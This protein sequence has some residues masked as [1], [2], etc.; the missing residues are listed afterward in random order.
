MD[1]KRV[2]TIS[3]LYKNIKTIC[4]FVA[5]GALASGFDK[6]EVYHIELACDEA[7][8]N[9]IEHAYGEEGK[10]D[11]TVSWRV[12]PKQFIV[13]LKDNGRPF[14]P[15]NIPTPPTNPSDVDDLQVGGLG[16]HFIKKL[17]DELSFSFEKSGNILTMK[18]NR[19]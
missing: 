12:T 9:I 13:T 14:N 5:E 7:C 8:T 1:D 2:L 17:M 15:A 19:K 18:K 4:D 3:G 6:R 10:G 11:I 16:L